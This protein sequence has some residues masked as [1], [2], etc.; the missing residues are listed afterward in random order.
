[1]KTAR[2]DLVIV[3][4]GQQSE[5]PRRQGAVNRQ[6]GPYDTVPIFNRTTGSYRLIPG[7]EQ[8]GGIGVPSRWKALQQLGVARTKDGSSEPSPSQQSGGFDPQRLARLHLDRIQPTGKQQR[9]RQ[10]QTELLREHLDLL[11]HGRR[12]HACQLVQQI[13]DRDDLVLTLC[14]AKHGGGGGAPRYDYF[15]QHVPFLTE[16]SNAVGGIAHLSQQGLLFAKLSLGTFA[17]HAFSLRLVLR[18]PLDLRQAL[19]F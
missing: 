17:S 1:M 8:W 14:A 10:S 18:A 5:H 16:I 2:S 11:L 6:M 9:A 19:A 13:Q 15:Q 4:D 7:I 12:A 3:F